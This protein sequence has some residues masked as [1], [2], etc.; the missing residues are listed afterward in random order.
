[1]S[2][3]I[4]LDRTKQFND[5]PV[6]MV[7]YTA[8]KTASKL[9]E[10]GGDILA[11]TANWLKQMQD[12]WLMYLFVVTIIPGLFAFLYCA[13]LA[14][15]NRKRIGLVQNQLMRPGKIIDGK[16]TTSAP[17]LPFSKPA[18]S[19]LAKNPQVSPTTKIGIK[20]F[21]Q[22]HL[23]SFFVTLVLFSIFLRV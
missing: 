17:S 18:L 2:S 12:N 5:T 4:L 6:R 21:M 13:Y 3:C 11:A 22:E 8:G 7:M 1:M 9:I 14:H 20:T 16:T 15:C 10:S 19:F 23:L